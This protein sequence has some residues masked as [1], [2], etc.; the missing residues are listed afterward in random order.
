MGLFDKA[1]SGLPR[2]ARDKHR[3][4]LFRRWHVVDYHRRRCW[5]ICSRSCW[6]PRA[7]LLCSALLCSALLSASL[8]SR[9][10]DIYC[11]I[12]YIGHVSDSNWGVVAPFLISAHTHADGLQVHDAADALHGL[13]PRLGPCPAIRRYERQNGSCFVHVSFLTHCLNDCFE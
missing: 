6:S 7:H 12:G 9:Y 11:N 8:G 1:D 13:R 10:N 3:G 2:Q 4:S 5:S